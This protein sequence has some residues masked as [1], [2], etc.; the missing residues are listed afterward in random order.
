MNRGD[1]NLSSPWSRRTAPVENGMLARMASTK[2]FHGVVVAGSPGRIV[3]AG[4]TFTVS[5]FPGRVAAG[6]VVRFVPEG[7]E[8]TRITPLSP[9][10]VSGRIYPIRVSGIVTKKYKGG[11]VIR[12]L[13]SLEVFDRDGGDTAVGER[14]RVGDAVRFD[15]MADDG[16]AWEVMRRSVKLPPDPAARPKGARRLG[17]EED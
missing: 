15:V 1:V 2:S 6:D 3:A 10:P 17:D 11:V 4:R 7:G 16:L 9:K 5:A 14:L 13:P 8:A 12:E